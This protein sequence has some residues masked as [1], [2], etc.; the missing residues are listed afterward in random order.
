M[1][2]ADSIR[3]L[4]KPLQYRG[5]Q[6]NWFSTLFVVAFGTPEK[7]NWKLGRA[8][9]R[10]HVFMPPD[11]ISIAQKTSLRRSKGNSWQNRLLKTATQVRFRC[12][13]APLE[14]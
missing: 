10:A 11:F 3:L 7:P 14:P 5:S 13:Y 6:K 8:A 12:F 1:N 2:E 9:Q 4:Q